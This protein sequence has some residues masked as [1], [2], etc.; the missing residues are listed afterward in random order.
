MV[1]LA[2][3]PLSLP[4][5]W[6]S[7]V[8]Y[9]VIGCFWLSV[10]WLQIR[11]RNLA[12]VAATND[13]ALPPAYFT[14]YRRWFALGW[15][16]FAGVLAIFWLMVAKAGVEIHSHITLDS[17]RRPGR[18]RWIDSAQCPDS[19]FLARQFGSLIQSSR[20]RKMTRRRCR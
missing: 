1:W 9:A 10:V 11:M 5:I 19:S 17:K 8:L 6:I 3:Y 16:A 18:G 13:T 4:W 14:Y 12:V 20:G 15:P 2:G 7:L